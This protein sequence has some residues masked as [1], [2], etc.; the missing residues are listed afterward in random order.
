MCGLGAAS[1]LCVGPGLKIEM[2]STR[3]V[4]PE[5]WNRRSRVGMEERLLLSPTQAML[6]WPPVFRPLLHPHSIL[7]R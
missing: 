7:I 4:C 6:G 3:P 2:G 5:W 1:R